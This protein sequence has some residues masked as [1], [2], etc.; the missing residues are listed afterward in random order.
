M[1]GSG[2]RVT[3]ASQALVHCNS[4]CLIL[5]HSSLIEVEIKWLVTNI[6]L[7]KLSA[8]SRCGTLQAS[9]SKI[10]K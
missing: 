7:S 3:A 8:P 1:F 10:G 2:S 4:I 6:Q 5:M 9:D